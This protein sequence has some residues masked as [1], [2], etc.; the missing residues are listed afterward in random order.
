MESHPAVLSSP[1]KRQ[2]IALSMPCWMPAFAGVT[3]KLR[4]LTARWASLASDPFGWNCRNGRLRI[5]A[6]RHDQHLIYYN[7]NYE[8]CFLNRQIL[9]PALPDV[10]ANEG[11]EKSV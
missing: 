9:N 7:Q 4:P 8:L 3:R 10:P 2:S 11:C 6:G 5:A 1:R